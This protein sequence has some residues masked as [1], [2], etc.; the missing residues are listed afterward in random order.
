MSKPFLKILSVT[1]A[2]VLMLL[3]CAGCED[4]YPDEYNDELSGY[5]S[6]QVQAAQ[7]D[8]SKENLTTDSG[9]QTGETSENSQKSVEHPETLAEL[10]ARAEDYV[11]IMNNVTT[12]LGNTTDEKNK[13]TLLNLESQLA[14]MAEKL[15]AQ[16]KEENKLSSKPRIKVKNA[17]EAMQ[18]AA[19]KA[20][21]SSGIKQEP[22]QPI[23]TSDNGIGVVVLCSFILVA[24][25]VGLVAFYYLKKDRKQYHTDSRQNVRHDR[26][27]GMPS[28]P[29]RQRPR[30]GERSSG[31]PRKPP[32]RVGANQPG[33]EEGTYNLD[34]YRYSPRSDEN[35]Q[36]T[37]DL[38]SSWTNTPAKTGGRQTSAFWDQQ[39]DRPPEESPRTRQPAAPAPPVGSTAAFI[40]SCAEIGRM[41]DSGERKKALVKL[42]RS[43]EGE[44]ASFVYCANQDDLINNPS[45][46]TPELCDIGS[47]QPFLRVGDYLIPS[48]I[49]AENEK[50]L[51]NSFAQV[52]ERGTISTI[53][54][55]VLKQIG[56]GRY[57]L[58]KKGRWTV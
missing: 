46:T 25:F 49:L 43:S 48:P 26:R 23:K 16:I 55:S 34:A 22:A 57:H 41:P 42:L 52:T 1:V 18:Q 31:T 2:I 3:L 19:D 30:P 5:T 7:K 6:S 38:V 21:N 9:S 10:E 13:E 8:G 28:A 51:L 17:R 45:T 54:P 47:S 40:R 29:E 12:L 56:P 35:D 50:R 32:V 4:D 20:R 53:E 39:D 15:E 27:E 58:T 36:Q 37:D 44:N 33:S 14:E 24:A 11:E